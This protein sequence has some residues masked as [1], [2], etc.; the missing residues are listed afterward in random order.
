MEARVRN[1]VTRLEQDQIDIQDYLRITGQDEETFIATMRDQA[2]HALSTRILLESIAAV[3]NWEVTDD[4][5]VEYVEGLLQG[6]PGDPAE[7]IEGWRSTGQIE[8]VT[9]DILR[10]RALN[11]LVDAAAPVDAEGNPVDLTP[12]EIEVEDE[13]AESDDEPETA[14][15]EGAADGAPDDEPEE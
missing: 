14:E 10:D 7:L 8:S 4:E 6:Q 9:G 5:I 12:V 2:D 13:E 3:E 11:S 1:L 15:S